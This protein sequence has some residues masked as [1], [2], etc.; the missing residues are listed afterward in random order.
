MAMLEQHEHK[1]P[2][3]DFDGIIEDRMQSPPVYFTVLFYV[4]IVWGVAFCA[5]FLLSGWSSEAEFRQEMAGLKKEV[6]E[7]RTTEPPK[8]IAPAVAAK[9]EEKKKPEPSAQGK[10]L[11][12]ANCAACHGAT[13]EGGIGPD[14]TDENFEYGH[15]LDGI[16]TTIRQGRPG[17]M[18]AFG[19]RFSK[20]EIDSLAAFVLSLSE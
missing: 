16:S 19:N 12:A 1:R 13:G 8:G 7:H 14:L 4:L 15:N 11:F 20:D 3:H 17:G 2:T 10:A 9:G 5:Y 6:G 18:P